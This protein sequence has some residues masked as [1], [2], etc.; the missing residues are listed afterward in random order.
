MEGTKVVYEP[1]RGSFGAKLSAAKDVVCEA[2]ARRNE[3]KS[4][5]TACAYTYGG[6]EIIL[7]IRMK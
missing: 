6:S 3:D 4:A 5:P 1:R 2:K 7:G